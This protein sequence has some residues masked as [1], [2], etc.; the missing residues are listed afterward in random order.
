V[1]L[2]LSRQ[3]L[4]ILDRRRYSPAAK[5]AGGGYILSDAQGTPDLILMASGSEV[6]PALAAK[7]RLEEKG[8]AVRVVSMP[9]W[10]LFEKT[11]AGYRESVLPATV[12]RRI[13]IEAGHPI[14]W[15]RYVGP[16]GLVIGIQQFGTSAPG[17][18]VMEKFGFTV[19][20]IVQKA[21]ALMSA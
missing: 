10:E 21:L 14:G 18:A 17:P 5:L 8:V 11:S 4:P 15:E 1:A 16:E 19:D 12:T 3:K 7:D 20:N 6:H 13:A 9:S 2:I